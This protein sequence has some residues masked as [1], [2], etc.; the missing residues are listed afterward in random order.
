[1]SIYRINSIESIPLSGG[2]APLPD[3]NLFL[4][5]YSKKRAEAVYLNL[6]KF[7]TSGPIDLFAIIDMTFPDR[8]SAEEASKRFHSFWTNILS[9][10]F[11]QY[12]RILEGHSEASS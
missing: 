5:S 1:L 4:S 2:D 8:P 3:G 11:H 7:F 12:I 6:K 9:P 10:Y